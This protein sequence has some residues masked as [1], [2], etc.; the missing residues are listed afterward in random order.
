LLAICGAARA[1]ANRRTRRAR[2]RHPDHA[3]AGDADAIIYSYVVANA[4][5]LA[6][7][8]TNAQPDALPNSHTNAQPDAL[9]HDHANSHS[10]AAD[11]PHTAAG[12]P[13]TLIPRAV[14]G[15]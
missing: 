2:Y 11:L 4:H 1:C 15:L 6:D 13:H 5:T 8:H 14:Y 12:N 7:A 10:A 9:A 3:G